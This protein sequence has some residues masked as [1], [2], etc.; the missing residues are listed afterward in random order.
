MDV[1]AVKGQIELFFESRGNQALKNKG[2]DIVFDSSQID[3]HLSEHISQIMKFQ[4]SISSPYEKIFIM[5]N[6]FIPRIIDR[7]NKLN[8]G[9]NKLGISR[10]WI[11]KENKIT[12]EADQ[13]LSEQLE[14][15]F[16]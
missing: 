11:N 9:L 7:V 12:F 5:A 16:E 14:D 2:T 3:I 13:Y 8:K 4:Q 10:C 15:I 6:P 1:R